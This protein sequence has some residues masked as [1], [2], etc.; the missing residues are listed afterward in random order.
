MFSIFFEAKN[1]HSLNLLYN[2]TGN[3]QQQQQ[4]TSEKPSCKEINLTDQYSN[5]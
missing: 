3:Q 4:T 2:Y 1:N 5:V